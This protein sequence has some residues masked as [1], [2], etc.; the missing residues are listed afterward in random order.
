MLRID[1][2]KIYLLHY[3]ETFFDMLHISGEFLTLISVIKLNTRWVRRSEG[4]RAFVYAKNERKFLPRAMHIRKER[5]WN[6]R[7]F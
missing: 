5:I 2:I 6:M 3:F 1:V 7:V 4:I